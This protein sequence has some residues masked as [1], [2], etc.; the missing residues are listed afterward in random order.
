MISKKNTDFVVGG[1]VKYFTEANFILMSTKFATL[2]EKTVLESSV[3]KPSWYMERLLRYKQAYDE[4][5][6][7][8]K[9]NPQM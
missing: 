1:N 3:F 5:L 9:N 4:K 6:K 2:N 8:Q 7:I